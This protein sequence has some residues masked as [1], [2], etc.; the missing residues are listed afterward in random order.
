MSTPAPAAKTRPE[1]PTPVGNAEGFRKYFAADFKSGFMVF[2]IALPLCLGISL[3]SG[4]PAIAGV[5]TAIVGGIL[6]TFISNAELTIKGPAA[7]LIVIA[8]GAVTELGGGDMILGYK[9]ALGIGVA[10]GIIQIVFGLL[11]VGILGEFFPLAA[12][13]GMLAAIGVII[14]SK[15]VHTVLGVGGVSGEPLELIAHIP[16]SIMH[17]NPEVALIGII[18]LVILIG[19]PLLPFSWAKK[20]PGPMVVLA[21]AIPLGLLFD[22]G[23]EHIYQWQHHD[24][25]VGP[26]YLVQ[27]PSNLLAAIVF[28]DF[29]ALSTMAGWKYVIMFALVGS[30]ESLL[31]AKAVDLL[32]PWNRRSNMDRDL[33]A[34]GIGN[35][36]VAFIG[37]L[38]MISEIVRSSANASNGARTRFANMWHGVFLLACVALIPTLIATI[39]M[40][41][42]AAML[43]YTG[44]RLASPKEF[45]ATYKVGTEQLIIFGMTLIM[46]LA[47]DLLIGIAA[48]IVTK[49][50]IHA[51]RGVP[52]HRAFTAKVTTEAAT[53]ADERPVITVKV[54]GALVF[55][56]W[57]SFLKRIRSL[58]PKADVVVDL[59]NA[60]LVDHSAMSKLGELTDE[61]EQRKGHFEIRGLEEHSAT[62]AHPQSARRLQPSA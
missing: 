12:V 46:T 48:G 3:A 35:T 34:V 32:D 15:Q 52:P 5:F 7:G 18:S 44:F 42:L 37:G 17:M 56:N 36:L 58:D 47:T 39:P 14:M 43:V 10:A 1:G 61:Y 38:P 19:V 8:V 51:V 53:D 22:L 33:L 57:L 45:I 60:T 27:V 49:I 29:S 54:E 30:L 28:P 4:Y 25:Q 11:K 40:A 55:S 16:S 2:L 24:Y 13:H 21:V 50:V 41:A 9:L 23:H 20:V 6:G 31:S 59:S 62:S 26:Q